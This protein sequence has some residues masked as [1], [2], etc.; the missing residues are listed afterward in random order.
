[1]LGAIFYSFPHLQTTS[2]DSTSLIQGGAGDGGGGPGGGG[3]ISANG[4]AWWWRHPRVRQNWKMVLAAAV[5]VLMGFGLIL[6]GTIAYLLP[7]LEGVQARV[8][9]TRDSPRFSVFLDKENM[10]CVPHFSLPYLL[11]SHR[12]SLWHNEH[13]AMLDKM[14]LRLN[15]NRESVRSRRYPYDY[16]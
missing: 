3:N 2:L 14:M 16:C 7:S 13:A 6:T 4:K 8:Y 5:L 12:Y 1:L 10:N 15:N 9:C 11:L